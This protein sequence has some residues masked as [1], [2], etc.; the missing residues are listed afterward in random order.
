MVKIQGLV[1]FSTLWKGR[2]TWDQPLRSCIFRLVCPQTK[3]GVRHTARKWGGL[4]TQMSTT[5]SPWPESPQ[6]PTETHHHGT[7]Q[8][9]AWSGEFLRTG[10]IRQASWRWCLSQTSNLSS[11]HPPDLDFPASFPTTTWV[12]KLN[13]FFASEPLLLRFPLPNTP[14]PPKP[15]KGL[16]KFLTVTK[17]SQG[18]TKNNTQ[19]HKSNKCFLKKGIPHPKLNQHL[20]QE[21]HRDFSH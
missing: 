14:T 3:H 8:S 11:I 13:S 20:L 15:P 9:M 5:Q 12:A 6:S 2:L 16:P 18:L 4:F 19:G 17:E 10:T 1:G 7:R 21:A